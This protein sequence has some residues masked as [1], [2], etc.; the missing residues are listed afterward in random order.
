M[1]EG[2]IKKAIEEIE[3]LKAINLLEYHNKN[4]LNDALV[5]SPRLMNGAKREIINEELRLLN[6]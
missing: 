2:S 4:F 5:R 3:T 1:T 6:E